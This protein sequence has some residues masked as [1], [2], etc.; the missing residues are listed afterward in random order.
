MGEPDPNKCC[1]TLRIIEDDTKWTSSRTA[2]WRLTWWA[3]NGFAA[4]PTTAID[5]PLSTASPTLPA[6]IGSRSPL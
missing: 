2:I 5:P 6:F 3:P 1:N 4:I